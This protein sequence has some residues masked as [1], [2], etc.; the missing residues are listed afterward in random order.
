MQLLTAKNF[1]KISVLSNSFVCYNTIRITRNHNYGA[2][3]SGSLFSTNTFP[4]CSVKSIFRYY[5]NK[6]KLENIDPKDTIFAKIVDKKIPAKIVHE[7]DFAIAFHD[8]NPQ[9]PVHVLIIPRKPIGGIGDI[10]EADKSVIGHLHLVAT[11][12]AHKLG[13]NGQQ[14][15]LY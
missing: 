5:T 2:N 6:P 12:V 15:I 9:A 14:V 3:Y 10:T 11:Q 7:D 13:A 1:C 4:L 8:V